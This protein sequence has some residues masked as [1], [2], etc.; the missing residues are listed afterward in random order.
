MV[1]YLQTE[2][3]NSVTMKHIVK[4]I[5]KIPDQVFCDKSKKGNS[6]FFQTFIFAKCKCIP[7]PLHRLR[8]VLYSPSMW[9]LVVYATKRKHVNDNQ[10]PKM[11]QH[12]YIE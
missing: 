12:N 10:Q 4:Y 11:Q 1:F 8:T 2:W 9:M 7:P 3:N 5:T 6:I